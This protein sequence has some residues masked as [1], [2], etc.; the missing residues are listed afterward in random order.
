MSDVMSS[1]HA[2]MTEGDFRGA[3][4]LLRPEATRSND[5]GLLV[6]MLFL[7][8]YGAD[9]TRAKAALDR[10]RAAA[11]QLGPLLDKVESCAACE[12]ARHA[13]MSDPGLA[14]Q[15]AAFKP[16]PPF[17]M[18]YA[19]AAHAHASKDYATTKDALEEI[20]RIRPKVPGV[21]TTVRGDK[22]AF[23]DFVDTDDLMGATFPI[24]YQ[25]QIYD[26]PYAEL[27]SLV[28]EPK[29]DPFYALW[30]SVTFDTT[31]GARGRVAFPSLYAGTTTN[32]EAMIRL[33]RT[34][35]FDHDRGY[36][37][38]LGLRDFW[39]LGTDGSKRMMGLTHFARIDF[40]PLS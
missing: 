11:P 2:R 9:F 36:A 20:G 25:K 38:A 6:M 13:R 21:V 19:K 31:F 39:V 24:Y 28:F 22:I 29:E 7:E 10:A 12:W 34:T 37:I 30:P 16:P 26:L 14:G 27:K 4:E 15:R 17:A 33:G 35:Y 8:C 5:P 40:G 32:D 3:A 1:A 18:L 23:A